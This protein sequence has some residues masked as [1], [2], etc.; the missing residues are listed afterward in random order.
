MWR[1]V[2]SIIVTETSGLISRLMLSPR[3]T[4]T[5][6]STQEIIIEIKLARRGYEVASRLKNLD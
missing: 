6:G 3:I 1:L 2:T 4:R 5:T